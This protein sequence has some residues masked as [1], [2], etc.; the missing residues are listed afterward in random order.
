[1]QRQTL[2]LLLLLLLLWLRGR[3]AGQENPACLLLLLHLQRQVHMVARPAAPFLAAVA[4][5]CA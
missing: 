3:L 2:L 4:A 5:V 1:M